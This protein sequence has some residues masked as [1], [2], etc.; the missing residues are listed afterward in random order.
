MKN[1]SK[2]SRRKTKI[3]ATLGPA[4]NTAEVI[5]QLIETGMDVARLNFSHGTHEE[6]SQ[7][8]E[9]IRR[10]SKRLGKHV[11]VF[12]DLCGPKIRIEELEQDEIQL[13]AGEN[14]ELRAANGQ[15]GTDK[16]LYISAFDPVQVLRTGHKA[17]LADGRIE[18]VAEDIKDDVVVCRIESGG[19]L[20]SRSGISVPQSK[21][22][23]P[24]MT[25]K[26][27]HDLSWAIENQVDYVALSFVGSEKDIMTIRDVM[28]AHGDTIP[29]IAKIER[30]TSLDHI[31]EISQIADAC[32]VARGDLGLELPLEK[33][34]GAQKLII[35]TANFNGTPVITATQMLQ[36]MVRETRPT[37][38]EVSDVYTALRDGTDAV[39]LS[40]ETA[41]G[42]NPVA[43]VGVLNRIILEAERE[44]AIEAQN[45]PRFKGIDRVGI[46]DATC[47]A[48]CSAASKISATAVLACTQSGYTA[49]LMSKYRPNQPLFGAT[50]EEKTLTRMALYWGVQPVLIELEPNSETEDE[51]VSA[52]GGIRDN[53]GFKP[54]S[55]VVITAGLRTKKSGTTN[56]MEIREI[57]RTK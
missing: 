20:R 40:E 35:E 24:C 16:T 47:Y 44:A 51:I 3:V 7:V 52:M 18:L 27:K 55:R 41:I 2:K 48:A 49:R 4:S 54:G 15:A 11:A 28:R 8:L 19:P 23:L 53:F 1:S 21:L 6:H 31:T 5:G 25:D 26:D 22:D 43:A 39:M 9:I 17:L 38:A 42:A 46:A 36:S 13:V 30:A 14:I 10:E 37:R 57:P 12:Q 56:L 45:K 29:V 32:M 34:P 50:T 33:V